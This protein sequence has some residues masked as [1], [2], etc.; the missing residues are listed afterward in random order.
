LRELK[1]C[2]VLRRRLEPPA[3]IA[4]ESLLCLAVKIL[5]PEHLGD[6]SPALPRSPS[7]PGN[8]A[9][10]RP[11]S[12]PTST[13][14]PKRPA[15]PS[16]TCSVS[17]SAP[18]SPPGAH[19]SARAST[20]P[21]STTSRSPTPTLTP[22]YRVPTAPDDH[23]PTGS[24]DPA[25]SGNSAVRVL[26]TMVEPRGLEPLTPTLPVWCATNC[27]TAPSARTVRVPRQ[28][29]TAPG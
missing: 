16:W 8:S 4:V 15:S 2:E 14:H 28:S 25:T 24:S 29:Y 22:V 3:P 20:K 18:S 13:P 21:S 9:P 10:G 23:E 1:A 26:E 27:A 7:A 12:P 5:K 19:R 6:A 17:T 11:N